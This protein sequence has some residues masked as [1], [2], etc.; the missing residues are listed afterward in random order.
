MRRIRSLVLVAAL[1]TGA[2]GCLSSLIPDH[3]AATSSDG[4]TAASSSGGGTNDTPAPTDAGGNATDD[5][6]AAAAA[7]DMGVANDPNCIAAAA[8]VIDGHHNSGQACLQCH[9]GNTA[10]ANKF[11]A[12]GTVYDKLALASG[13]QGLSGVTI[14]I[15]DAA[16]TKV[17]VVTASLGAPGNF[18]TDQ[19]LV[20]PLKVRASQCPADRPMTDP[21]AAAAN[22]AAGGGN[23]NRTGCHDS[24]MIIHVP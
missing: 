4:G 23:C 8:P 14:E 20:F 1:A 13:A 9:D 6:G 12:A 21:V 11:T 10:G 7:G 15:T 19:A 24:A 16:G 17:S 18:W 3:H 5:G 22:V 2:G